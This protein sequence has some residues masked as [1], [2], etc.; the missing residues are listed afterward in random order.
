MNLIDTTGASALIGL[1]EELRGKGVRLSLA[2]ARDDVRERMRRTG[3]EKALGEDRIYDTLA[4]G[5]E[6][7][8]EH[9]GQRA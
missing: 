1:A 8:H 5:V 9:G 3:V 4:D 2:R 7:F 6:A